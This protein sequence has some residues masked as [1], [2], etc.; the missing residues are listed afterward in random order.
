MTHLEPPQI[1]LRT[2]NHI[3]AMVAYWDKNQRCL[4][5]NDAYR[6]WFGKT[7]EQ[8]LGTTLKDLLGP[9]Y[10]KN[11]PYILEALKGEKQI[12]E[13][14]IPLPSGGFRDSI[15]TYTPDIVGGLVQG[16]SSHVADVT[17]LRERETELQR[18]INE[19]DRAMAE[20][21]TLS[22]L[23]PICANCKRIRD[24]TGEWQ[25]IERYVGERTE[26]SFTHG[27]CPECMDK[28]YPEIKKSE[29]NP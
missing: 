21:R 8:M 10:E 26:A 6:E 29:N 2:V 13:R 9:L 27:M 19:R 14:R 1:A 16:F 4:F 11:I 12:F 3:P 15:A 5:S 7:P 28:F 17:T 24:N 22:G 25:P 18:V 20:V 23:L